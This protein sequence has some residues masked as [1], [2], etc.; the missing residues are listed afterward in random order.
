MFGRPAI[1]WCRN[2]VGV[3]PKMARRS[4][5]VTAET[6]LP[7]SKRS[8]GVLRAFRQLTTAVF[9]L[10]SILIVIW[11]YVSLESFLVTDSRFFLPGPPEPG[12]Q[13]EFFRIEGAR[14]VT[15][16]QIAQVFARDFGRSIYLLPLRERRLKL[17]GVD[18]VKDASI[19]RLWP[20][21]L[22]IRLKERTPAAFAQMTAADGTVL[23][24]LVDADGVLLNPQ[25]ARPFHLPVLTGMSRSE[26][27]AGRRERMKRFLR[28]QSELGSSMDKISEIDVSNIDNLKVIQQFDNRALTLMLGNQSYRERY[29]NFLNNHEEIRK[30]LPDAITLDLRL[31]DR[32]T[33]VSTASRPEP[34]RPGVRR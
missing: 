9:V 8:L 20:N 32:I 5:A 11:L 1:S 16:A 7:S 31:T 27:D 19:S 23:L 29:E 6:L 25:R 28:L 22:V 2:Y 30:R 13:S 33:A 26:G 12:E 17:L 14:N 4:S 24:S 21:R 10:V 15:E 34:P 3:P 18:W